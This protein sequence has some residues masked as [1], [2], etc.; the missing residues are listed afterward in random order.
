MQPWERALPSGSREAR[1]ATTVQ[2]D[3]PGAAA[4]LDQR[5]RERRQD[6]RPRPEETV[7]V[8]LRHALADREEPVRGRPVGSADDCVDS[9][10]CT[11][12]R[13]SRRTD[14]PP[15]RRSRR[16]TRGAQLSQARADPAARA[17]R[18]DRQANLDP[19]PPVSVDPRAEHEQRRRAAVPAGPRAHPASGRAPPPGL[20][21]RDRRVDDAGDPR[22]GARRRGGSHRSGV[23]RR[24]RLTTSE[25]PPPRR[26]SP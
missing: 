4:E 12:P 25:R 18:P 1:A 8:C 24:L 20:R 10:G 13:Y 21:P 23:R 6:E 3:L 14:P 16:G 17:V 15:H 11:R 22:L 7:R 26:A 9:C 2:R 19:Q 5:R